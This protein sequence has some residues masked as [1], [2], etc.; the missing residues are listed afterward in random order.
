MHERPAV[1]VVNK[2]VLHFEVSFATDQEVLYCLAFGLSLFRSQVTQPQIMASSCIVTDPPNPPY[3]TVYLHGSELYATVPTDPASPTNPV[4]SFVTTVSTCLRDSFNPGESVVSGYIFESGQLSPRNFTHTTS[5]PDGSSQYVIETSQFSEN[6]N[7]VVSTT[8]KVP[9]SANTAN[10]D[11]VTPNTGL[12]TPTQT[13]SPSSKANTTSN[14]SG[15]KSRDK[16]YDGGVV[17]GSAIG[18]AI[19]AALLAVVF[20]YICMRRR[21]SQH[22]EFRDPGDLSD[23]IVLGKSHGAQATH[24]DPRDQTGDSAWTKR[25]P[26][27]VDDYDMARRVKTLYNQIE[28]HV[29]NFYQ[30]A[31][32]LGSTI[33]D[34]AQDA[35]L[36]LESGRL[37]SSLP[38]SILH[39]PASTS[40]IKHTLSWLIISR[41]SLSA[42]PVDSFLPADY[43][44]L[45]QIVKPRHNERVNSCMSIYSI[46]AI[47][48]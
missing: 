22:D 17:A 27:P 40:V 24:E 6:G 30:N 10:S 31:N 18:A 36:S 23:M 4:S 3:I 41:I 13:S 25:M 16:Q 44:G 37:P 2:T 21:R 1:G 20:T 12:I 15:S 33:L 42:R 11:T 45:T 32:V 14:L 39:S 7:S 26:H 47:I 9:S 29:E 34:D 28:L 38:T 5:G 19:G 46:R 35:L 48:C 8:S 43:A